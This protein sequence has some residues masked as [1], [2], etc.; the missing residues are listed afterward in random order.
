MAVFGWLYVVAGRGWAWLGGGGGAVGGGRAF[1]WLAG[2]LYLAG[3]RWWLYLLAVL[4]GGYGA[5]CDRLL[6][7]D[8]VCRGRTCLAAA[9]LYVM[10]WLCLALPGCGLYAVV[11]LDRI[12]M[13]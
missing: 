12:E 9:G 7:G 13:K 11:V 3:G 10:G 1:C 2:W 4:T 5:V 8:A 6:G